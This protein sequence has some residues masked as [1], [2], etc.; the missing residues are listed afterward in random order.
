M[1]V[2]VS[3]LKADHYDNAAWV[4]AAGNRLKRWGADAVDSLLR[5]KNFV[6]TRASGIV[7]D[8]EL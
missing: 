3:A 8:Y 5:G 7:R 1:S 6:P 4:S 2:N